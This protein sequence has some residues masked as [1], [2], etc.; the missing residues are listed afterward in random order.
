[1]REEVGS[2]LKAFVTGATGRLGRLLIEQLLFRSWSVDAFVLPQEDVD[3]LAKKGI[4]VFRGDITDRAS[5]DRAIEKSIPDVLFHLAA[6][7][8]PGILDDRKIEERMYD[9][10]VNGTRNVLKSALQHNVRKAVYLSSVAIFGRSGQGDIITEDT[11]LSIGSSAAQYGKTKLLAY[12]EA[13]S[14]QEQGLALLVLIPGII[15]GPGIPETI[16]VLKSIYEGKIRRLPDKYYETSIPLI[17]SLDVLE[18]IFAAMERNKFGETYILAE[19]IPAPQLLALLAETTGKEMNF[20]PI[21]YR[22]ALL[23]AW[24]VESFNRVVGRTPRVTRSNVKSL[25]RKYPQQFDTSK[26]K[27]ELDWKPTPLKDACKQ[28]VDWFFGNH[29]ESPAE[30]ISYAK[31]LC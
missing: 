10:N 14:I 4:A 6:Y 2:P 24:L 23:L 13:M 11:P 22:K 15:F 30:R 18:A 25:F 16:S 31:G 8:K 1:L 28:T 5:I 3:F 17:F 12:Q 9:V 19:S 29:P 20:K 21:S 7:V 27:N 26:A